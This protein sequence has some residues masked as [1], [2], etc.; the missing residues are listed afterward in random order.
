MKWLSRRIARMRTGMAIALAG[1]LA[2]PAACPSAASADWTWPM[3]GR[4]I[5]PYLNDNSKPYAGGMH[6]GIDIAAPVGTTVVAAYAGSVTYA[7]PL[8]RSGLTVAIRTSDGRHLTSYLHLSTIGVGKG[9]SVAAGEKVGEL[10]TSGTRSASEP[11][12]HFGVR[13]ADSDHFYIDPLTLL[14]P[15][16]GDTTQ[17]PLEPVVAPAPAHAQPAPVPLAKPVAAPVRAMRPA[18]AIRPF[19]AVRPIPAARSIPTGRSIPAVRPLPASSFP[20]KPVEIPRTLRGIPESSPPR[21]TL[22]VLRG[23][24]AAAAPGLPRNERSAP[25]SRVLPKVQR[26]PD[27]DPSAPVPLPSGPLDPDTDWGRVIAVL[28][29]MLVVLAGARRRAPRLLASL[30]LRARLRGKRADQ[31]PAPRHSKAPASVPLSQMS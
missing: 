13:L 10:G 16:G 19:P 3:R 24:P 9:D 8:G 22:P 25:R 20:A 6:R 30:L 26:S 7:A 17:P 1:F 18:G 31:S 11:H 12:L 14:P 21:A 5:T 27:L 23:Q 28:G 2:G 29:L 4:V 15:L